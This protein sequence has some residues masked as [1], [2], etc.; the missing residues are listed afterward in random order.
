MQNIFNKILELFTNSNLII[1]NKSILEVYIQYCLDKNVKQKIRGTTSHH[2]I[3]PRSK[4]LP[5]EQYSRLKQTPWNGVHLTHYD[6]YYAHYLLQ[7]AIEH[8]SILFA[9]TA[10]HFK[11]TKLKR[12]TE[13]ELIPEEEFNQIMKIRNEEISKSNNEL[14]IYENTEMTKATARMLK[15][16]QN[17]TDEQKLAKSER[18]KG[19]NNIACNPE[20][21]A[22]IRNTKS[23][24][25][26]NGKNLD[27]ISAE[28]AAETMNKEFINS[29]G[30]LTTQYIENGKKI[31]QFYKQEIILDDGTITTKGAIR[32]K[33]TVAKLQA[34]SQKFIVK[35][36]FDDTYREILPAYELRKISANLHTK[37]KENYLG[38]SKFAQAVFLKS[39]KMH[40]V[41]LYCEKLDLAPQLGNL[42]QDDSPNP[43]KT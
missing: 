11:D 14:V 36:I 19:A 24:T 42:C 38:K 9:F 40:L 13:D 4:N 20:T 30:N 34:K 18:L 15:V 6:H 43:E 16:H 31:S 27:T 25:I 32:G 23:V 28:R 2:H 3:L 5:F 1:K 39:N 7:L 41:G 21:L 29:D 26:I 10:M 22:K 17:M 33:A 35:N 8:N 12:I 37:T